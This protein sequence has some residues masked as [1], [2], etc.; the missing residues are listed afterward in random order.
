MIFYR[1]FYHEVPGGIK[2]CKFRSFDLCQWELSL[3][4]R[5]L[6]SDR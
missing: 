2:Q 5:S 1:T 3:F 4:I 6:D